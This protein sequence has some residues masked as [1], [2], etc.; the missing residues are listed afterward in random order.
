MLRMISARIANR[1]TFDLHFV[2]G[3]LL[4]LLAILTSL[5]GLTQF[6]PG[7]LDPNE[8]TPHEHCYL[9]KPELIWMHVISDALIGLSYIAI[10]TTLAFVGL[11]KKQDVPFHRMLLAFG[12]FLIACGLTHIMEIVNVWNGLYWMA[13][14]LKVIAAVTSVATAII[15]IKIL[16]KILVM[17]ESFKSSED[18]RIKLLLANQELESFASSI[19][20]D[21]RAPL[22]TMQGM[23]L[24]LQQDFAEQVP[25]PAKVYTDKIIDAAERMDRLIQDLLSYSRVNLSEL[26]LTPVNLQAVIEGIKTLLAANIQER[27]AIVTMEGTFPT[28]L[29]SRPLVG[30]I[31]SNILENAL[32]FV[33]ADV[34]PKI[35]ILGELKDGCIR[36]T[37]SDNGIGIAPEHHER[38]FK[39]FERVHTTKEISGT[40]MGLAIVQRA[41]IRLGGDFGLDSTPGVGTKFW[42]DLPI[43]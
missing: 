23:A 4:L 34:V 21:L 43:A 18:R 24:V 27:K 40:G 33:D 14:Y 11:R 10:S 28:V 22:R 32:K 17:I 7:L 35:A 13:G 20:H 1:T 15:L 2:R 42:I 12:V 19:A 26:N 41:M 38:I 3:T 9:Y 36:I 6:I 25:E 8:F 39:M 16:P 5:L 37:I 29:A 30:Q 31:I